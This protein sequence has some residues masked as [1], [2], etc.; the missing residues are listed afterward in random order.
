METAKECNANNQE[1]C[2]VAKVRNERKIDGKYA[3]LCGRVRV[4]P[5]ALSNRRT[6]EMVLVEWR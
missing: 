4:S 6:Q 2:G 3:G 1:R 5:P